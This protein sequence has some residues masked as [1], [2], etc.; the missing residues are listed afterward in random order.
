MFSVD[1]FLCFDGFRF[2]YH[3]GVLSF[4]NFFSIFHAY[5]IFLLRVLDV[6]GIMVRCR[7][8]IDSRI[9][10][11]GLDGYPA[12]YS[13]FSLLS[14][15][16]QGKYLLSRISGGEKSCQKTVIKAEYPVQP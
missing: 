6:K 4:G 13:I 7:D 9:L 3:L 8:G 2:L 11:D 14:P 1:I 10:I 16:Y 5:T 15:G 12:V